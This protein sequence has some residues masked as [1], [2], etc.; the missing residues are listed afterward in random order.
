MGRHPGQGPGDPEAVVWSAIATDTDLR[1]QEPQWVFRFDLRCFH[2]VF[3]SSA[4]CCA[5]CTD[6]TADTRCTLLLHTRDQFCISLTPAGDQLCNSLLTPSPEAHVRHPQVKG[7][8]PKTSSASGSRPSGVSRVPT[9][10]LSHLQIQ[11]FPP[12]DNSQEW[13]PQPRTLPS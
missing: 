11:G 2:G 8:A 5:V 1:S 7:S 12:C 9:R 10:L 6:V 3:I 4:P 13:L